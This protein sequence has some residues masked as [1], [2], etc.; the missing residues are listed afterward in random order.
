MLNISAEYNID[1]IY[2][3]KGKWTKFLPKFKTYV[4]MVSTSVFAFKIT[5]PIIFSVVKK[6]GLSQWRNFSTIKKLFNSQGTFAQS[7]NFSPVKELLYS[8]K[9]FPQLRKLAT[10]MEIFHKPG[11][12][13]QSIKGAT[14]KEL[15]YSQGRFLQSRNFSTVVEIFCNPG[16]FPRLQTFSRTRNVFTVKELFYSRWNFPQLQNFSTVLGIFHSHGNFLQK[17]F[18]WSRK[19]STKNEVFW[20]FHKNNFYKQEHFPQNLFSLIKKFSTNKHF[21]TIKKTFSANK[22][23]KGSLRAKTLDP[24]ST[25]SYAKIS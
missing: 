6:V 7:K 20:S 17:R 9:T 18:T 5:W 16:T 13:P 12:F 22:D 14:V 4:L 25:T 8:Q 19:F 2:C 1:F 21:D 24:F 15:F 10:V 23:L 3:K 11:T